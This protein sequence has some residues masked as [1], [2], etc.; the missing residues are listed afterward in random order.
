MPDPGPA[1][2]AEELDAESDEEWDDE[3]EWEVEVSDILPGMETRKASA[4]P[5]G[6]RIRDDYPGATKLERQVVLMSL[7]YYCTTLQANQNFGAIVVLLL[8]ARGKVL[9][10][11]RTQLNGKTTPRF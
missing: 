11:L 1:G 8:I 5:H 4:A 9:V 7:N 10:Q 6:T 3:E 2:V